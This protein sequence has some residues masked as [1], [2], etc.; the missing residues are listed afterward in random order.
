MDSTIKDNT[1]MYLAKV[2][3]ISEEPNT[4]NRG[5]SVLIYIHKNLTCNLRNDLCVSGK[6]KGILTID[7]S[8]END[9][10]ILLS[11]C[12]RPPNGDREN[13]SAFLQKQKNHRKICFRKKN[14]YIIGDFNMN[15]VKH[16]ENTKTKYC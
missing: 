14:S 10:N 8:R 3:I 13:L 5:G 2:N 4:N 6:D 7:I 12:Y 9:K 16:H 1:N 15:C 11:S